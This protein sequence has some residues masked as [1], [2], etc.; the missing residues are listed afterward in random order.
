MIKK[1]KDLNVRNDIIAWVLEFLTRRRQYVKLNES[2]SELVQI[3][4]GAPQGCVLSP[5][6]YTFY[7]NDYRSKKI[8]QFF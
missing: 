7:T 1:L 6:L 4:T 8:I 2:L 5:T 3:N